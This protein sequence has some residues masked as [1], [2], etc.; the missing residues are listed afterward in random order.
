MNN[1][2][3]NIQKLQKAYQVQQLTSEKNQLTKLKKYLMD[4]EKNEHYTSVAE[5]FR[6]RSRNDIIENID[7]R[8][9][10]IEKILSI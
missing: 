10:V 1:K 9:N 5:I 4:S 2:D 8:L 6:L 3:L 7:S